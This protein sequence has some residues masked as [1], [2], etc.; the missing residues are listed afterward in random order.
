MPGW[1]WEYQ[2]SCHKR[3]PL[4]LG[5]GPAGPDLSLVDSCPGSF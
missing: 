3:L 1:G 4:R 2:G 5:L